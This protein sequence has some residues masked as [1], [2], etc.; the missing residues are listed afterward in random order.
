MTH[1][2]A[3]N[4]KLSNSQSNKLK[5]AVKD[6]TE[7]TLKLSSNA[8]SGSN[9][10]TSFPWKLLLTSEQVSMLSK[11]FLNNSSANVKLSKTRLHETG[12]SGRFLGRLLWTLLKTGLPLMKNVLKPLEM[13]LKDYIK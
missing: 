2:N 10:A 5:Y 7:V 11:A 3:L 9:D 6:G 1:Y 13:Y 4:V 12:K 8:V